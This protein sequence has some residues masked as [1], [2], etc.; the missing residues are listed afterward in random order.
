ME[1]YQYIG[2]MKQINYLNTKINNIN[3][4]NYHNK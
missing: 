4:S 1:K 2:K 3:N